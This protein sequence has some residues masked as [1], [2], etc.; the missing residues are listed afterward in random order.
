M[1]DEILNA[2][3]IQYLI[4]SLIKRLPNI[5]Y[6]DDFSDR[7]PE[8]VTFPENYANDNQLGRGKDREWQ[9]IIVEIFSR[10]LQEEFSLPT[11]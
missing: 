8:S 1:P 9:E 6:F 2:P 5:L 11:F 7:V 3:R 10:A 4:K